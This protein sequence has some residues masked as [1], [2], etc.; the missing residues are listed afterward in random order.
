MPNSLVFQTIY[1]VIAIFGVSLAVLRLQAADWMSA[2][3]PALIA[4]FCI[5]R[6]FTFTEEE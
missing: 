4:A 5:Y 6:L 3:W 2:L 1:A